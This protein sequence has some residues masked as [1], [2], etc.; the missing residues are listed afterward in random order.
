MAIDDSDDDVFTDDVADFGDFS[1]SQDG[2]LTFDSP[3]DFEDPDGGQLETAEANPGTGSN[4]Y[5]VVVQ[6]SDGGVGSFVNWFKVIVN[7][8]DL[9]E[10]GTLAEWT[11]DADG[12]VAPL[13]P[14]TC[15]CSSSPRPP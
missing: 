6:A 12:D 14:P 8:T 4:T 1:I 13:R 5:R 11:V 15:C 10:P 9:E 2:V 7:V 3:P